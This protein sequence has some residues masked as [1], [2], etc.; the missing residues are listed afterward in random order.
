[1]SS[2]KVDFLF[3]WIMDD[4]LMSQKD[5]CIDVD[6]IRDARSQKDTEHLDTILDYLHAI[7]PD[8]LPNIAGNI[9]R[10]S[11]F[12]AFRETSR[13]FKS[14]A[15]RVFPNGDIDFAN[16]RKTTIR[17]HNM[18]PTQI[19]SLLFDLPNIPDDID[20]DQLSQALCDA[21]NINFDQLVDNIL[22]SDMEFPGRMGQYHSTVSDE[23]RMNVGV[24]VINHMVNHNIHIRV[25][26]HQTTL[27][28]KIVSDRTLEI[29]SLDLIVP[30]SVIMANSHQ[31]WNYNLVSSNCNLTKEFYLANLNKA[32]IKSDVIENPALNFEEARSL[33][34]DK[35]YQYCICRMDVPF[36]YLMTRILDD[37][38]KTTDK[39][40]LGQP[41][42]FTIYTKP[43][44]V[45][46]DDIKWEQLLA[47]MRSNGAVIKY[48]RDRMV[49]YSWKDEDQN[50][51]DYMFI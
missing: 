6:M 9:D 17:R 5:V 50:M 48:A 12:K 37:W 10:G 35:L 36:D 15:D 21:K 38:P 39:T 30:L 47:H 33:E 45:A 1:M 22:C 31:Y 14:V 26:E 2:S 44:C 20:I 34:I 13:L 18:V 23:D 49:P 19:D 16:W 32:W 42:V 29:R 4:D 8:I 51:T 40:T 41:T 28:N 27:F 46:T 24:W 43:F 3:G 11:T 25:F 7:L